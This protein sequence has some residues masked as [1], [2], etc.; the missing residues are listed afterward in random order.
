MK[1]RLWIWALLLVLLLPAFSV[2]ASADTGPKPSVVVDFKGLEQ[3]HYYVTLLS[4]QETTGPWTKHSDFSDFNSISSEHREIWEKL[5]NYQDSDG[6]YFLGCFQ[7]CSDTDK[8]EWGYH[9]PDTFKILI[10]FPDYDRFIVSDTS[11]G[12]YAFDSYF[13]VDATKLNIQSVTPVDLSVTRSYDFTWE[14]ISLLCRIIVTISVELGIAWLFGFRTKKQILIIGLTN[15]VTQTV[16]N[17]LLNVINYHQGELAFLSTYICMEFL[18]FLMEGMIYWMLLPRY[19]AKPERELHPWVYAGVAN[20]ASF[21]AGLLIA[22]W[23]P[24]IF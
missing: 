11:Y 17:I 7:D 13:T 16:L 22:V 24:G 15:V 2:T 12:C 3:E 18:V 8:F 4:E 1:K 23:V 21:I 5:N 20:V 9:P 19:E 14:M 6:F 10:Y